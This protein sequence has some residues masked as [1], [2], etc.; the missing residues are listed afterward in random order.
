MRALPQNTSVEQ[1]ARTQAKLEQAQAKI[2]D[3]QAR[4]QAAAERAEEATGQVMGLVGQRRQLV[5]EIEHLQERRLEIA[6]QLKITSGRQSQVLEQVAAQI[7]QQTVGAQNALRAIETLIASRSGGTVPTPTPV[8]GG[9]GFAYAT[10]VP[11]RDP[12][13]PFRDLWIMST[14]TMAILALAAVAGLTYLRR[15]RRETQDV[16]VQLRSELWDEMKKVSVGVDA[17]AVELERIGEGQRFVTK[18]LAEKK[19]Q[20]PRGASS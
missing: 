9:E 12:V 11:P 7:D 15:I 19:E 8:G 4:A 18:A 3:A 20:A 6:E 5:S 2:A 13:P 10:T 1:L 14:G 16:V 17:I